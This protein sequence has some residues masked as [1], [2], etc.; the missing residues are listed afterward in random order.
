MA[1]PR[2]KTVLYSLSL[3]SQVG[4]IISISILVGILAGRWLD[5]LL[6]SN[7]IFSLIGI[8]FGL[9]GGLYSAYK[10]LESA[11]KDEQ[12]GDD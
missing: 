7:I 10:L 5:R 2:W 1:N 12:N 6:N 9:L 11:L 3:I 4:L 8:I